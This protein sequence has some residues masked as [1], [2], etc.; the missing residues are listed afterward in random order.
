MFKKILLGYLLTMFFISWPIAHAYALST[1]LSDSVL[2]TLSYED[3]AEAYTVLHNNYNLMDLSEIE[4]NE[5][6]TKVL[7]DIHVAKEN[8]LAPSSLP[9]DSSY[10]NEAEKNLV[11]NNPLQA[12][13]VFNCAVNANRYTNNK[14][15]PYAIHNDNGDAYRH[16]MW[17]ALLTKEFSIYGSNLPHGRSVA[18]IWTDAHEDFPNNP[19]MEKSMDLYN[20]DVGRNLLTTEMHSNDLISS[21]CS[22]KVRDGRGL[23]YVGGILKATNGDGVK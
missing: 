9:I 17:N 10:L 8:T 11:K 15:Q 23:R 4:Q 19:A 2:N 20:N 18:K 14:Y 16:M 12:T 5:L 1:E 22:K 21:A 13:G 3:F 7:I 6:A